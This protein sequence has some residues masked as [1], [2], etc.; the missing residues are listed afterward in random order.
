[1]ISKQTILLAGSLL[2]FSPAILACGDDDD[3]EENPGNHETDA[4]NGGESDAS[5]NGNGGNGEQFPLD[6]VYEVT[7][8]T[9][10]DDGCDG[11]GEPVEGDTGNYMVLEG[12][13]F[14]GELDYMISFCEDA[15]GS[16]CD[17]WGY[18]FSFD[19]DAH[20][21]DDLEPGII[22]E[23]QRINTSGEADG[24]CELL[25]GSSEVELTDTGLIIR[26]TDDELEFSTDDESWDCVSGS[27][28]E[29]GAE[30]LDHM[31]CVALE[32]LESTAV[33]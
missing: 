27:N 29:D 5:N 12:A 13:A 7:S 1:M 28:V 3:P 6:G 31:E 26:R 20:L 10:Q 23:S 2:L 25:G 22:Y 30:V 8:H 19:E 21:A 18:F 15:D 11:N 16:D 33:E 24:V 9:H 32:V 4:G 17:S 14:H